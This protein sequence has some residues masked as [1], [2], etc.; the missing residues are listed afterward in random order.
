RAQR[1][2]ISCNPGFMHR[3]FRWTELLYCGGRIAPRFRDFVAGGGQLRLNIAKFFPIKTISRC[4]LDI[5]EGTRL[6]SLVFRKDGGFFLLQL[7]TSE[8]IFAVTKARTA[9]QPRG[10]HSNAAHET[11]CNC[12]RAREAI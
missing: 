6:R 3:A 7:F 8:P 1:F 9:D 12:T 4:G 11:Y 10:Q 2:P 5:Q